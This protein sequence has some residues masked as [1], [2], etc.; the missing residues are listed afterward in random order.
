MGRTLPTERERDS[1][2]RGKWSLALSLSLSPEME[3]KN[4]P[5]FSEGC[6]CAPHRDFSFLGDIELYFID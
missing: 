6:L 1:E 5:L 4:L 3:G 2:D